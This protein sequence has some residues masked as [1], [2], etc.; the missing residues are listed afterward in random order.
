MQVSLI[1]KVIKLGTE[2]VKDVRGNLLLF[3]KA[4][5]SDETASI[6]LTLWDDHTTQV[7]PDK[8]YIFT[9]LSTRVYDGHTLTSTPSTTINMSEKTLNIETMLVAYKEDTVVVATV[10]N[11]VLNKNVQCSNCKKTIGSPTDVP[12]NST[13]VRCTHCLM[14]QNTK[15]LI[16]SFHGKLNVQPTSQQG[17]QIK[18]TVFSSPLSIFLTK[19][20]KVKLLED[21]EDL[22]EFFL[23]TGPFQFT[24][25][26]DF[27]IDKIILYK[28]NDQSVDPQSANN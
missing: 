3:R 10:S 7:E 23:T 26:S 21:V 6:T 11:I 12:Q 16:P 9:D 8:V 27:V 19:I 18:L 28:K 1:A 22:E 20:N 5:I 25:S 2:D 14:K 24:Y 17:H 13:F 15:D 4:T